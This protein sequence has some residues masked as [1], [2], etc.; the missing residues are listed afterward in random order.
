MIPITMLTKTE[1]LFK[2][3]G[4]PKKSAEKRLMNGI[5]AEKQDYEKGK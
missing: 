3:Q 4:K 1:S 5:R 2:T